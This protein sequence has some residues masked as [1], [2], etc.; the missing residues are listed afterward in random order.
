MQDVPI[1]FEALVKGPRDMAGGYPYSIKARDLMIN[2][3][4]INQRLPEG[5]NVGDMLYWDGYLWQVLPAPTTATKHALTIENGVPTWVEG[6][7]D[8]FDVPDVCNTGYY[9]LTFTG[10]L[11]TNRTFT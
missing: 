3:R 5:E 9:T 6:I 11:L 8:T 4:W 2:F 7:D 10:G 1:D